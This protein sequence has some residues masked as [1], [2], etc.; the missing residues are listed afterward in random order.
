MEWVKV[1]YFNKQGVIQG[2]GDEFELIN[3][4]NLNKK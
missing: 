2:F 4:F 1:V 3:L